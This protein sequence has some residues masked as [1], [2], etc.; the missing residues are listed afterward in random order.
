M[1]VNPEVKAAQLE[2]MLDAALG[3]HEIGEW[4]EVDNGWQATC[5]QCQMKTWI[6]PDGLRYSLLEDS[7]PG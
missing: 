5:N 1:T 2:A 6:G 7:C 4:V 3:G